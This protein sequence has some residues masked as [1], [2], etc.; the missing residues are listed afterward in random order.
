MV[1]RQVQGQAG[2]PDQVGPWPWKEEG[3]GRPGDQHSCSVAGG[4]TDGP[5]LG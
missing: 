3:S 5:R 1:M 4:G 2:D